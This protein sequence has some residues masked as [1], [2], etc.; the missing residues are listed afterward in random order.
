MKE[1]SGVGYSSLQMMNSEEPDTE[2][3]EFIV[4]DEEEEVMF[5]EE[6]TDYS[7]EELE[8]DLNDY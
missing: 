4:H 5:D 3:E 7:E 1:N 2:D 6:D 8:E